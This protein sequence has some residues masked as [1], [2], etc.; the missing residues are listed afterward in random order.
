MAQIKKIE[1]ICK[2]CHK[3]KVLKERIETILRCMEGKHGIKIKY[4]FVH[5][6][7]MKT[8]SQFGY[9]INELPVLL[10]NGQLA[11]SGHVRGEHLVRMKFEEI[12][13]YT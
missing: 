3:C 1:L 10:I 6:Q 13:R 7:D 2:P 4:E 9:G 8:I 11:F 5:Y 12:M